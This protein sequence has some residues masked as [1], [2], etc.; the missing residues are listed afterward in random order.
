M[1]YEINKGIG[2]T[3]EFKGLKAQ[4][5]YFFAGGLGAVF[6]LAVVLNL[7]GVPSPIMVGVCILLAFVLLYIIFK[8]NKRYG[9]YGLMKLR[10]VAK[11]PDYLIHRRTVRSM[12]LC[13]IRQ[14]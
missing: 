5:L 8:M 1:T 7:V 13:A 10:A 12:L 3:L 11:H 6:L 2:A 14:K 9:T 4:Y